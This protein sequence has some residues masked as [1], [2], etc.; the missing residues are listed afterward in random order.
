MPV[1]KHACMHVLC[2]NDS[3]T[4]THISAISCGDD[5]TCMVLGGK[6]ERE[7]WSF[8]PTDPTPRLPIAE[9]LR[10]FVDKESWRESNASYWGGGN[11]YGYRYEDMHEECLVV[12]PIRYVCTYACVYGYGH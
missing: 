3:G 10:P 12:M 7:F 11:K 4:Y 8:P 5:Y 9:D 1:C 6:N 2:I